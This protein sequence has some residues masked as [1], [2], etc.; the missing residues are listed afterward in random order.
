MAIKP[1]LNVAKAYEK[2]KA[3]KY[4][5]NFDILLNYIEEVSEELE[6]KVNTINS[7]LSSNVLS[8]LQAVYPI[9][10]LFISTTDTCPIANLFGT[11]EKVGEGL[12][13]NA[14][15]VPVVGNGNA[16]T[17]TTGS[18]NLSIG[19]RGTGNL[20]DWYTQMT[21]PANGA[22]VGSAGSLIRGMNPNCARLGLTENKDYSGMI[23]KLD[24]TLEASIWKRT[25]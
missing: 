1:E 24:L 11:W 23:A 18:S 17:F 21:S 20:Q 25:A 9:G 22:S 16:I 14:Q 12:I 8:N 3:N 13:T 7:Q 15:D 2:I 4:N 10:S 19:T 6:L 5:E